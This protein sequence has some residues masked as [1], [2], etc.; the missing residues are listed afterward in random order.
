MNFSQLHERLRLEIGRRIN[1]GLL[2]GASLAARSGLQPSH[3]SNFLRRKRKL[4]LGAL[5]R[6]LAALSLSI[7]DLAPHGIASRSR[8][9]TDFADDTSP[10]I[11]L[12]SPASAIG[13]PVIT[14]ALTLELIHIPA[15][16]LEDLRP[17]R[18]S[19]RRDWQR[20]VAVRV[21]PDQALPMSP[22]L[23][24]QSIVVLDRQYNSLLPYRPPQPNIYGVDAG[25]DV[26]V[27]RYVNFDSA[28]IILRPHALEYPIELLELGE[29]AS[30]S[31]IIV[32][33]AC[34]CISHL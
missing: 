3:I 22:V 31:G 34:I 30:P 15:G 25:G 19:T 29:N 4:S 17:R 21:S 23:R 26:L 10:H 1:R 27:F 14:P 32:G 2:T 16:I 5:D 24:P 18:T 6:V 13:S 8:P 11:P 12:V 33:R 20:F 7:D 9:P 28:R